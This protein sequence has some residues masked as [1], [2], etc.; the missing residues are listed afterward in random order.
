MQGKKA[1][2]RSAPP[3]Y[4]VEQTRLSI[5]RILDGLEQVNHMVG[6]AKVV[7]DVVVLSRDAQL[8]ELVLECSGLLKEAVYFTC[9]LHS[10]FIV[11]SIFPPLFPPPLL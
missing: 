1:I 7:L 2:I 4:I 6:L 3:H 11:S 10:Y 9:Y 8:D 5:I